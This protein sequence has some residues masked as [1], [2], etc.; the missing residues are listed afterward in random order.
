M[1]ELKPCPFCGREATIRFLD[2]EV[3]YWRVTC[4]DP[5]S[6]GIIVY[7]PELPSRIQAIGLWNRRVKE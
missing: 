7:T 6:C 2:H 1:T 4:S 5:S 3:T